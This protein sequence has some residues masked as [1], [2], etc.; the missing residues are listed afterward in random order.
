MSLREKILAVRAH[1]VTPVK[2]EGVEEQ[3]YMRGMS[4]YDANTLFIAAPDGKHPNM[5][6]MVLVR[7]LCDS[8]GKRILKDEDAVDLGQQPSSVLA[9][10][11]KVA[12]QES[13][14]AEEARE[15][16]EKN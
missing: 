5:M 10:L 13:G 8:E 2:M 15:V 16:L 7:C 9:P 11:F 14:L 4:A 1:K 12:M 6:A 3:L